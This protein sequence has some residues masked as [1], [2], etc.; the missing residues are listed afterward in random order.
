MILK[1][2]TLVERHGQHIFVNACL[3]PTNKVGLR[4]LILEAEE[5]GVEVVWFAKV[6]ELLR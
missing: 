2:E 5:V 3:G 4:V 6:I 1:E